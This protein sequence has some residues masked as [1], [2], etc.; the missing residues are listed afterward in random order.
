M[1]KNDDYLEL[2]DDDELAFL[3]LE[4]KTRSFL[5]K[6]L[7]AAEVGSPYNDYYLE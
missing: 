3:Q 5:N 4:T 2:P 7:D 1:L 6:K